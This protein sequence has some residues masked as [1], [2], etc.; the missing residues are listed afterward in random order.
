M[1]ALYRAG[2]P[3]EALAAYRDG[4]REFAALGLEPDASDS[5]SWNGR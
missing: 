3:Q 4:Y 5:G 2:R 1:L